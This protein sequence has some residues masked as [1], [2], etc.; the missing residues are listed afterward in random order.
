VRDDRTLIDLLRTHSALRPEAP[1]YEAGEEILTF[2]Q[3]ERLT[4]RIAN[5]LSSAG[6]GRDHRIA[7][8]TKHHTRCLLL[9]LAACKVGAVCVPMNWRLSEAEIQYVLTHSEARLLMADAAFMSKVKSAG[10]SIMRHLLQIVCTEKQLDGMMSLRDLYAAQ[11]E[12]LE[13]VSTT[14]DG[15][16]LQLYSSGTTG[17]PKG[18]VLTHA[19]LVSAAHVVS[20]QMRFD[21]HSVLS[22][23]LPTF[24][25]SGI[26]M[27]LVSLYSGGKSCTYCEFDPARFIATIGRDTIT[28]AV[29][30]PAMILFVLQSPAASSGDY[31]TLKLITYGGAPISQPVLEQAMETFGC[32]FLQ[33]YGLTEVCGSVTVL[34]PEDHVRARSETDLLR[35]AGRA[36][37]SARIRIVD[38]ATLA[39]MPEAEPGEIWVESVRNLKEYWRDPAATALVFPA[40][41]NQS[42]GWLRTGD[43]GFLQQGFVYIKDRLKD[44]IISGGENIYPAEIEN[45]LASHPC[46]ADC[47]VIGVPDTSWGESVK[48][49]LV[50]KPGSTATAREI[51]DW[52]RERIAHYKC[53]KS[54]DFMES[55]PRNPGGKILKRMLR[56]P[57]WKGQGREI[58]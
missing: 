4:N 58:H 46:V 31:R 1:A 49:C 9:I 13:T 3:M 36:A 22:N 30:V 38:T 20:R 48:A 14:A 23:L 8:L 52:M 43:V 54:I 33:I 39:E 47:A 50:L 34:T 41:R 26:L 32:D 6:I 25:I 56:D 2:A 19:G 10:P 15:A 51:I 12:Q 44:M 7:C 55:L 24:H 16:A 45:V 28:H 11:G 27:L 42:G 57:Y 17:T 53:P 21:E 40:G 5:A 18:V 37:E 35:S 29:L